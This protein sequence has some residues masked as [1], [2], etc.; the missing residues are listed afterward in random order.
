MADSE[1]KAVKLASFDGTHDG[2]QLWWI[3]F[4]SYAQVHKFAQALL[5]GGDP[6]LP[7]TDAE[8][9]SDDEEVAERQ[10]KAKRRNQIAL[11]QFAMAFTKDSEMAMLYEA[12]TTDWPNGLATIVVNALF[13]KYCPQDTASLVELQEELNDIKMKDRDDPAVLFGKIAKIKN[14]YNNTQVQARPEQLLAAVIRAA[15]KDYKAVLTME[16]RA[17]GNFVTLA[18]P[19]PFKNAKKG[20]R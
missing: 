2:F 12:E 15:P 16:Q 14:K 9:L 18:N 6:D 7:T 4:K 8:N 19:N 3:R 10:E 11:A 17:K 1:G 5:R 13:R 20:N